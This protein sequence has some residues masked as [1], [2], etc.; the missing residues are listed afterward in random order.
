MTDQHFLVF[1]IKRSKTSCQEPPKRQILHQVSCNII[2][3]SKVHLQ[4]DF[5]QILLAR[6]IIRPAI[7]QCSC[8]FVWSHMA[9]DVSHFVLLS[10]TFYVRQ[11]KEQNIYDIWILHTFSYKMINNLSSICYSA[12]FLTGSGHTL[13]W[14]GAAKKPPRLTLPFGV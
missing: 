2:S 13:Y 5:R 12:L 7:S 14:T 10:L 8:R 4:I 3:I 11:L 1:K 9:Q 6:S